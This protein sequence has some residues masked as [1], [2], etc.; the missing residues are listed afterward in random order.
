MR[1]ACLLIALLLGAS[2][3]QAAFSP[4]ARLIVVSDDSYP[5]YLF[6][7][8]SGRLEGILV[9]KWALWS[10]RTGVPVS[11]EGMEWI[12]AQRSVRDGS[13]DVIDALAYT[14]ARVPQYEFSPG[15][16]DVDARVYFHKTIGG[17]KDVA[18][19]RGFTIGAKDGSA[20]AAWL[21]S[22]SSAHALLRRGGPW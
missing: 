2:D 8:E 14:E 17:I 1:T 22:S 15:Y 3:V 6:R 12:K 9:D 7:T 21:L 10:G 4:P 5:P 16:A 11:I 13:A 19:M 20:C 18:S